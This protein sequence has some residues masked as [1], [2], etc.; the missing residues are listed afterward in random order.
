MTLGDCGSSQLPGY[1]TEPQSYL[2]L[3][4]TGDGAR[5]QTELRPLEDGRAPQKR[6]P[7]WQWRH[8]WG[9]ACDVGKSGAQALGGERCLAKV[10]VT[11]VH[12]SPAG[13]GKGRTF[14]PRNA[15]LFCLPDPPS[16]SLLDSCYQ[17]FKYFKWI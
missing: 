10:K 8:T 11:L 3:G 17:C 15:A 7:G 6:T 16:A 14:P 5:L 9:A 13:G 1:S 2:T 4:A 12:P